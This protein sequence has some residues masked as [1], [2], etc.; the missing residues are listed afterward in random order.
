MAE[1]GM[2][3]SAAKLVYLTMNTGKWPPAPNW[4]HVMIVSDSDN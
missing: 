1:H 3:S 2:I 4:A